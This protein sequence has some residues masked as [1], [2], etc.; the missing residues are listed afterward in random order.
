MM[1]ASGY[2]ALLLCIVIKTETARGFVQ[3]DTIK[4]S[5]ARFVF[6]LLQMEE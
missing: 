1:V 5:K 3:R 6:R 2:T 4:R